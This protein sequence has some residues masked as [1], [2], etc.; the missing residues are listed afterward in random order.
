MLKCFLYFQNFFQMADLGLL[1]SNIMP[2]VHLLVILH[3]KS[4]QLVQENVKSEIL[5]LMQFFY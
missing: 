5:I 3:G 4:A 1:L 2:E